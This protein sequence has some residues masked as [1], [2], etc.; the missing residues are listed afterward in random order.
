M[1]QAQQ[2]VLNLLLPPPESIPA[3]IEI[4]RNRHQDGITART[5]RWATRIQ[6]FYEHNKYAYVIKSISDEELQELWDKA[7]TADLWSSIS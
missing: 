2:D 6:E 1:T 7:E 4:L 5:L 3:I